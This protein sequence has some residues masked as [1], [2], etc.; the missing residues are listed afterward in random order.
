M[1]EVLIGCDTMRMAAARGS[2]LPLSFNGMPYQH[3]LKQ[4]MHV[5]I[6]APETPSPNYGIETRG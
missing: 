1:R 3:V 6:Q 5:C 2:A 4:M